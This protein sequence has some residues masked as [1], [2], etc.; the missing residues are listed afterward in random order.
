MEVLYLSFLS[1]PS[2]GP[3]AA[4][5]FTHPFHQVL[6]VAG[7]LHL[8]PVPFPGQD[9]HRLDGAT[10]RHAGVGGRRLGHPVVETHHGSAARVLDQSRGASWVLPVAAIAET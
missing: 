4:Y 10:Q 7:K 5:P 3:P 9:S 1:L 6:R 2:A 8:E